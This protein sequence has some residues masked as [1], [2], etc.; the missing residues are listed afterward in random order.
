[1]RTD[2]L[3]LNAVAHQMWLEP[4]RPTVQHRKFVFLVDPLS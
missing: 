3:G 2:R 4:A 1:M